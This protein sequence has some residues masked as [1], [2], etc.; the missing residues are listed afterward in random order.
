MEASIDFAE[1]FEAL[2]HIAP[3][4]AMN[5]QE[6][7]SSKYKPRGMFSINVGGSIDSAA[8]TLE[9]HGIAGLFA[10]S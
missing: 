10:E 5:I 2:R 7:L 8:S 6:D 4:N 1:T 3:K 9:V